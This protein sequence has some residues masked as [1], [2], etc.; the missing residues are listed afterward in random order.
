MLLLVAFVEKR[1][2]W[3]ATFARSNRYRQHGPCSFDRDPNRS[4]HFGA[5]ILVADGLRGSGF[6]R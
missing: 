4:R 5:Q 2:A 3:A 1:G 6:H